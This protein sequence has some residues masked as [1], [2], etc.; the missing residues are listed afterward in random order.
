M[1]TGIAPAASI[2]DMRLRGFLVAAVAGTVLPAACS[3]DPFAVRWEAN[4]DT[5]RLF[6]LSHP[7]PNLHSAFD[8]FPRT[9]VRVEA[10]TTGRSW[11]L[12]VDVRDGAFVWL[13]PGALG[14][15]SQSGVATLDGETFLSAEQAPADRS[16]Y[17]SDAPVPIAAG[18][19]YAVR[20]RRHPGLFGTQCNYYGKIEPLVVDVD[21]RT[22]VFQFDVSGACNNR[23]LVPPD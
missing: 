7:T 12:A 19:V 14:I 20:T 16:E 2:E 1:L 15:I 8:F 17:V 10:P 5:V 6:A 3:D 22:I 9:P 13:P 11:D 18:Q 21:A 23:S 4:P